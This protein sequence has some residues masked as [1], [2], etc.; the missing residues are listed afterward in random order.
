MVSDNSTVPK[1]TERLSGFCRSLNVHYLMPPEPMPMSPHWD[2][3]IGQAMAQPDATHFT[4][5]TDR[6]VF[7]PGALR[8]LVDIVSAMPSKVISY[9]H[10][11]IDDFSRPVSLHEF[12]W[13]G[14]V[15]EIDSAYLLAIG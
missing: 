10:D 1:E 12:R 4:Y 8:G 2:W 15:V 14:R 6:M 7:R 5:L 9:N 3:A 13:T 11:L